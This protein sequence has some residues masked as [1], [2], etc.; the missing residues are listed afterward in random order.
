MSAP[1]KI[2]PRQREVLDH[3]SGKAAFSSEKAAAPWGTDV[4]IA[5]K[6]AERGVINKR[7]DTKYGE[8]YW[9]RSVDEAPTGA[10]VPAGFVVI[11]LRDLPTPSGKTENFFLARELYDGKAATFRRLLRGWMATL[12]L[13]AKDL[14]GSGGIEL[15]APDEA[16]FRGDHVILDNLPTEAP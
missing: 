1:S 5:D 7:Y 3:L 15:R 2:T 14:L 8:L 9:I 12:G 10:R 16:I 6:L 4:P 13:R 11:L